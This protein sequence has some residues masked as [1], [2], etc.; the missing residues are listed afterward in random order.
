MQFRVVHSIAE[1]PVFNLNKPIFFDIEGDGLYGYT[2][3]I[4]FYQK[5]VSPIVWVLDM[6]N[7]HLPTVLEYMKPMWLVGYNT[8]YDYSALGAC[9]NHNCWLP[10]RS[11]DL[12]YACKTAFAE[13]QDFS[14]VDVLEYVGLGKLYLGLDKKKLQK[15]GFVKGAYLSQTQLK[16]ASMD[17]YA[18]DLLWD[19]QKVKDAMETTAYQLDNIAQR[20]AMQW[21]TNGLPVMRNKWLAY[22]AI[23]D[24]KIIDGMDKLPAGLNPRSSPQ[25]CKLFGTTSSDKPTLMRLAIN[26]GNEV[27]EHILAARQALNDKSKLARYVHPRMYGFYNVAGAVTGRF[28]CKGAKILPE[29]TNLQNYPRAFKGVFG[30]P[31][32]SGLIIVAADYST[33]ELRAAASIYRDRNMYAALIRGEDLHKYTASIVYNVPISEVDG[34]MRSNA[35]VANFGFAFGLSA[36]TFVG[37][38]FDLYGLKFTETEAQ[39]LKNKWF[40]AYPDIGAYHKKCWQVMKSGKYVTTTALGRRICPKLGTDAINAPV[41]GSVAE[42][43]KLAIQD[44]VKAEPDVLKYIVNS[45]HDSIYLIVPEAD[46]KYWGSIVELNMVKAWEAI[47]KTALMYYKDI[48]MPVD[49]VYGHNMTDLSDDFEGGGQPLNLAEMQE[50][51]LMNEELRKRNEG[52]K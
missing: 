6:D 43:M 30:V 33:A 37:Y 7:N 40:S 9:L 8:S 26:D 24:K 3:L 11:A 45:V 36:K 5:S 12:F 22:T 20:E 23:N 29:T 25:V 50:R 52:A 47:S 34:R 49:I 46:A 35:K 38:A 2:R 44:M 1:L 14:L 4:Q 10:D 21:Q 42:T 16:Y 39:E 13:S 48:P 28:S 27:A 51:L 31:E 19:M 32:D 41:Q 18:L 15:A 17:V